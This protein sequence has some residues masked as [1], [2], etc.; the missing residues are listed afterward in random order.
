MNLHADPHIELRTPEP[1]TH[2]ESSGFTYVT[3]DQN[4]TM[5]MLD[6]GAW[7]DLDDPTD[8]MTPLASP[9]MPVGTADRRKTSLQRP[10]DAVV[11]K[12][13]QVPIKEEANGKDEGDF[14]LSDDEYNMAE[15]TD[16]MMATTSPSSMSSI[17]SCCADAMPHH[18]TTNL[19][20]SSGSDSSVSAAPTATPTRHRHAPI[21][22]LPAHM[23]PHSGT[24]GGVC[25][26]DIPDIVNMFSSMYSPDKHQSMNNNNNNNSSTGTNVSGANKLT[27]SVPTPQF[28]ATMFPFMAANTS[29]LPPHAPNTTANDTSDQSST[30][31]PN[32]QTGT[33]QFDYFTPP[34]YVHNNQKYLQDRQAALFL[35]PDTLSPATKA[36]LFPG[37]QHQQPSQLQVN[38][39]AMAA[40]AAAMAMA[41]SAAAISSMRKRSSGTVPIAPLQ[42]KLSAEL[43][44]KPKLAVAGTAGMPSSTAGAMIPPSLLAASAATAAAMAASNAV[45]AATAAKVPKMNI[46]PDISDFKLVQIFHNFCDPVTKLLPLVRFHQLLQRHQVKDDSSSS[47][48]NTAQGNSSAPIVVSQESQTLFKVLDPSA[49]GYLDL[50]RFMNSFQICNRCTE[51]K[52]RAHSAMCASQGQ[53]V[54]TTALE[55]HLMEDVTPVIVRV[56]P[57]GYEGGKVKS[58]EHYQWTWCEGF[59]KTGNEK[60]KGTNR[61]DKCPKYLANC[62]LW[63]HKLPPKNRKAKV[64]ENL[65]SPS[66]KLRHFA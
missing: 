65:D 11:I 58:C 6:D 39:N 4:D 50:E 17:N 27:I 5:G 2:S 19:V 41:N 37:H 10:S 54:V 31:T 66:K 14:F 60:C 59:E 48:S 62:T 38:T 33:N 7:L 63:K 56:V 42:R 44:L 20:P 8:S 1:L 23:L 13:E 12:E 32:L 34:V 25:E 49:L 22:P 18:H 47:K 35:N 29:A 21:A 15:F 45:A 53:T 46:T 52:R 57:T 9:V 61:H 64:F 24:H 26:Q 55:R 36:N 3:D 43:P 16:A 30:S 40:A 51:A 28:Y